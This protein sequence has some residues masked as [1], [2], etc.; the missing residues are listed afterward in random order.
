MTDESIYHAL[1]KSIEIPSQMQAIGVNDDKKLVLQTVNVPKLRS[2]EVLIKIEA[3]AVNRADLL[4]AAG[5]YPPPKGESDILGLECSGVI[6]D[7][8]AD[9]T[10][11]GKS[12]LFDIGSRVMT[13][14]SAG[15]YAQY[16]NVCEAHLIVVPEA[17]SNEQSAAI[18]EAFLTAFQLLFWY[19]KPQKYTLLDSEQKQSENTDEN[20]VVLV[21]AGASG[22][23]T[24]L[25]QYCKHYGLNAFVTAGSAE[26]I[27][28]CIK[29]GAKGGCNYKQESFDEKLLAQYQNGADIVLDCVGASHWHKNMN[30]IAMDGRWISY[31]FLSGSLVQPLNASEPTFNISAI[32]RKRITI[33]GSTLRSRSTEYK[34]KLVKEFIEK[35]VNP[36]ISTQKIK[37]IVDRVFEMK[38]AQSAHDYVR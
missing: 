5:K 37:P 1:P 7:Y 4:Q 14:L 36:L 29:L 33:I 21:H 20:D 22:V 9:C 17:L 18:P 13:L 28:Y 12:K 35:I 26:K 6:V 31:G 8:A 15:G 25:I 10:I 32:L 16:V 11:A 34:A 23:G 2:H 30:A 19:G 27:E 3:S 24:T 38:D